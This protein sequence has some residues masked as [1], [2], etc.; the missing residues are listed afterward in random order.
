MRFKNINL[1][2]S[3]EAGAIPIDTPGHSTLVGETI[4]ECH[5]HR[6]HDG[7]YDCPRCHTMTFQFEKHPSAFF[8]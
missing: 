8:D 4:I 2:D 7:F 3:E 5:G 6:I 1:L